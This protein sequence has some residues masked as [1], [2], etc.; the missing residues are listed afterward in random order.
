MGVAGLEPYQEVGWGEWGRIGESVGPLHKAMIKG[1]DKSGSDTAQVS[2][3]TLNYSRNTSKVHQKE[4]QQRRTA[5]AYGQILAITQKN[6]F[7]SSSTCYMVSTTCFR[8]PK[9]TGSVVWGFQ[10]AMGREA[11]GEGERQRLTIVEGH[12]QQV[13]LSHVKH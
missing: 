8:N 12:T 7:K 1:G 2:N 9:P 4:G 13:G 11:Q 3:I 5:S 10:E 6:E